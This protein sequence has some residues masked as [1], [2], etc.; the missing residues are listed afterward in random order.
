MNECIVNHKNIR[1][2]PLQIHD[3]IVAPFN[4]L[5][6]KSQKRNISKIIEIF[7]NRLKKLLNYA[8]RPVSG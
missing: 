4:G 7:A 5:T 2:F 1:S 3:D 6:F 8:S